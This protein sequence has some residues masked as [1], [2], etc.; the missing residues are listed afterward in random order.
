MQVMNAPPLRRL[1]AD[2]YFD[3]VAA[4]LTGRHE[5]VDGRLIAMAPERLAHVRAKRDITFALAGAVVRAGIPCEVFPD[6]VSVQVSDD[7]VFEPDVSLRCGPLLPGD[8]VRITDPVVVVE[9]LSPSTHKYDTGSKLAGY[10][11][12]PSLRHYLLVHAD[13]GVVVHHRRGGDGGI[14]TRIVRGGALRL[15]PPGI[16]FAPPA[17]Q[18]S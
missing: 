4:T 11:L 1:T 6:G 2:A 13:T 18:A 16:D 7:T 5:L 15:D 8:T 9:V 17:P 14:V 12:L 3:H 10:F